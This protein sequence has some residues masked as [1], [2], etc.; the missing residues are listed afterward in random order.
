MR[1]I[2]GD[3]EGYSRIEI[4]GDKDRHWDREIQ[5]DR[6]KGIQG[7]RGSTRDIEMGTKQ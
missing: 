5:G 1:G 6:L 2:Q 3:K 7:N 4:Q